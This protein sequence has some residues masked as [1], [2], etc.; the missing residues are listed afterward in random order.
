MD[1]SSIDVL[2]EIDAT[3]GD[4]IF[5]SGADTLAFADGGVTGLTWDNIDPDTYTFDLVGGTTSTY[6][7][8]FEVDDGMG[9]TTIETFFEIKLK[10]DGTYD[11]NLVTPLPEVVVETPNLFSEIT[12]FDLELGDGK[13]ETGIIDASNFGGA[14]Q[15]VLKGSEDGGVTFGGTTLLKKS[16]TD[17]GINGNSIQESQNETLKLDVVRTPGFDNVNLTSLTIL[18][19]AT[20]SIASG[21][22]VDLKVH[23]SEGSPATVTLGKTYDDS[24]KLVFDI[25]S[26]RTVDYVELIPVSNNVTL[27]VIGIEVGYSTTIDPTDLPLDF[28]LT[29]LDNDG[30]SVTADFT[31]NLLGGTSGNDTI[32]TG[33]DNDTVSG[34]PGDD[35]ISTG[36]GDD[37][38]IGGK[39]NDTL[40]GGLGGDT[41]VW[42]AGDETGNPTDT[43]T[44]FNQSGGVYIPLEGDVLDLSALLIGEESG[45]LTD[46]LNFASDGTDT[47]ITVDANGDGSGTD[48]TIVLEGV[49]LTAGGVSQ[50]DIIS[51]LVTDGNLTVD[52]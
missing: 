42:L 11:F 23:Y 7:A 45:V 25:E 24:G 22:R 12:L 41:F 39:D 47:T 1:V 3:F 37:I 4:L 18:L 6:A 32:T 20:G 5:S 50:A 44:D 19:S 49:D 40:T 30:D 34:G 17:I 51:T 43:I 13:T 38:L 48:Q 15:L 33:S 52:T 29:G 10:G 46:Y 36:L 21:D 9:G 27:K 14:F 31:V 26:T 16:S 8:T 2:R 35:V 28:S